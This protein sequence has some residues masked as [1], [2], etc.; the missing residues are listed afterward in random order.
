VYLFR[1]CNVGGRVQLV[2]VGA[3]RSAL[4]RNVG[5]SGGDRSQR[6]SRI[7]LAGQVGSGQNGSSTSSRRTGS[8]CGTD[9]SSRQSAN[10]SADGRGSRCRT[11]RD[12]KVRC[13]CSKDRSAVEGGRGADVADL[14]HDALE[15]RVGRSPLRRSQAPV[16]GF[17]RQRGC[18]IKKVG[19]LRQSAIGG[20]QQA[21]TV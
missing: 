9:T 10:D 5:N 11:V 15:L 12:N 17:R 13:P 2:D 18:A 16:H 8:A 21:N 7:C 19:P 6:S 1:A 3:N 4:V 14:L 20:L